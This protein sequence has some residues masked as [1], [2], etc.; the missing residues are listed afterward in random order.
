MLEETKQFEKMSEAEKSVMKKESNLQLTNNQ[1][2]KMKTKNKKKELANAVE[3]GR[4]DMEINEQVVPILNSPLKEADHIEEVEEF[5]CRN[6]KVWSDNQYLWS[7][8]NL[9]EF[10]MNLF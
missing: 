10:M 2:K 3:V 9:E 7:K 1:K 4:G 8:T 5:L 6:E